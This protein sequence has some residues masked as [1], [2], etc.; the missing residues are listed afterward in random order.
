MEGQGTGKQLPHPEQSCAGQSCCPHPTP[1]QTPTAALQASLVAPGMAAP[2]WTQHLP[3]PN[4]HTKGSLKD[5]KKGAE[6][7]L[8]ALVVPWPG[9]TL[10]LG[11]VKAPPPLRSRKGDQ[12]LPLWLSHRGW[13]LSA[14]SV[15]SNHKAAMPAACPR[16][17]PTWDQHLDCKHSCRGKAGDGRQGKG[18]Q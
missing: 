6:L 9:Q 15:H 12:D 11:K 8:S 14:C 3:P 7:Q 18:R 5:R 4:P 2:T 10:C 1:L 16:T 17:A 13:T